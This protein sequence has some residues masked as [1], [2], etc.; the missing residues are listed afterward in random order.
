MTETR[1]RD[2]L[3]GE[4]RRASLAPG[5]AERMFD[6]RDRRDRRRRVAAVVESLALVVGVLALVLTTLPGDGRDRQD[7]MGPSAVAGRYMTRLSDLDTDVARLELAGRYELHLSSD[8]SLTVLSPP[9]VDMPGPPI[10]FTVTGS[11]LTTDLLLGQGCEAPG[12]YRWSRDGETLTLEP[13]EEPCEL[14]SVILGTRAWVETTPLPSADALQGEWRATFT[15]DEMAA[16]VEAAQVTRHDEAF[17][18]RAN[19]EALG[20]PD[21]DDP[22]AG[23]P[24]LRM[25]TLRFSGDRLQIFDQGPSEGFDG[26]YKL[27]GDI[28]TIRDPR[29]RNIKGA[30]RLVV[31]IGEKELTFQLVGRGATDPWFLSTWQ[32]APFVTID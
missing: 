19:A 26:R 17:W 10:G 23:S 16:T 22:C 8:G 2:A 13:I 32:V 1:L 15:C 20:S 28:L 21:P 18:R 3:Q 31:E 9:D 4:S 7:V 27:D 11:R 29:S 5:A 24:P 12:T 6:R 25:Y 14:R 30:Y